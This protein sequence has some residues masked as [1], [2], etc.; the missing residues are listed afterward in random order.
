MIGESGCGKSTLARAISVSRPQPPERVSL[1]GKELGPGLAQ[2]SREELR[3]IQLVFQMADTALNPRV[4]IAEILGRPLTFFFGMKGE[5]R[6]RRVR[7]LLDL[8]HL[9][10]TVLIGCRAICR[11][12]KNSA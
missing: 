3:E 12:G 7:E 11:A 8:T 9:P 10:A 1:A 2:R 5:A 4:T 6:D